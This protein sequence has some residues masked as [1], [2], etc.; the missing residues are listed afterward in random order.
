M[1]FIVRL[2]FIIAYLFSRR[3]LQ[4]FSSLVKTINEIEKGNYQTRLQPDLFTKAP[5]EIRE[6]VEVFNQMTASLES[7]ERALHNASMT[8]QLTI[9][10]NCRVIDFYLCE[11]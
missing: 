6:F 4:S 11:H 5:N 10:V 3:I 2:V 8:D 7:H 1:V 9:I